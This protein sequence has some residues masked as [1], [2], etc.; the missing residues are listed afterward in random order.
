[1]AAL[2]A[3][4]LIALAAGVVY[5]VK[6]SIGDLGGSSGGGGSTVTASSVKQVYFQG[7]AEASKSAANVLTGDKPP[8]RTD[9]YKS[10]PGFGGLKQGTGLLITLDQ[11][12]RI[13]SGTITSPSSGSTVEIRIADSASPSSID[14]TQRVWSGTL[15]NGATEFTATDAPS[16]RYVLVWITG[17]VQVG[18]GQWSTTLEQVQLR[19]N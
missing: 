11:A 18:N 12:T 4:V 13:T 5:L 19:G 8:W 1:F 7:G 14:D 10:G 3:V 15:S 2:A 17:L 16:S 9:Y 6:P